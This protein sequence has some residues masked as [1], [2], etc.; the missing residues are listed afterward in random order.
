[1]IGEDK[2][3]ENITTQKHL[4]EI[5]EAIK[6]QNELKEI[7]L[8]L[9]ANTNRNKAIFELTKYITEL[10]QM[11]R[12]DIVSKAIANFQKELDELNKISQNSFASAFTD[13]KKSESN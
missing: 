7:E 11:K 10:K 12:D 4:Y 1:M 2:M 8:E 9:Y 13:Y 6:K 3:N 5:R